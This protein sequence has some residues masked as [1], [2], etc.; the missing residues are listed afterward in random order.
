MR[1]GTSPSGFG[2]LMRMDSGF[3]TPK[4][5]I[6]GTEFAGEIADIGNDLQHFSIGDQ[7]FGFTGSL[8]A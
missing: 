7:V 4:Q 3:F 2:L 5:P 8:G 1:S 6:L